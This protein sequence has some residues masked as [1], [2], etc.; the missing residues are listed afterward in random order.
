MKWVQKPKLGP[1]LI[2]FTNLLLF[3]FFLISWLSYKPMIIKSHQVRI[4]FLNCYFWNITFRDVSVEISKSWEGKATSR[5]TINH[6]KKQLKKKVW[7]NF[8]LI[9]I[10]L[11]PKYFG[12][13]C[14]MRDFHLY[15][16]RRT[17]LG[18]SKRDQ[19]P[20][21]L[22][23]KPQNLE[24]TPGPTWWFI[25]TITGNFLASMCLPWHQ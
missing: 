7:R 19:C 18:A 12:K 1:Q 24:S 4:E 15:F 6:A 9:Y 11:F 23:T 10:K 8:C 2:C 20:K 3:F 16:I 13:K 5:Y 25:Q 21:A 14:L 17:N 22:A